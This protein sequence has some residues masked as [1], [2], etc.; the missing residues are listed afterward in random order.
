MEL[1][2][3]LAKLIGLTLAIF[4]LGALMRPV[5]ISRVM[6][7]FNTHS[8]T[9]LLAGFM[10]MVIGLAMVLSH[11]VWESSWRVIITIFGW[12]A[13]LKGLSYIFAPQAIL[14]TAQGI[15]GTPGRARVVLIIAF[16]FGAFLAYKGFGM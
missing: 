16:L 10:G 5:V 14:G 6:R 3:F 9:T 7:D 2:Y 1:S 4:A 12:I 15:L 13:L 8:F 11:N